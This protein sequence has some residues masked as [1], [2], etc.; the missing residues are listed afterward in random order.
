MPADGVYL[1]IGTATSWVVDKFTH[2]V[3]RADGA[4]ISAEDVTRSNDGYHTTGMV[5]AVTHLHAG[6][7]VSM[8]SLQ[9]ISSFSNFSTALTGLLIQPDF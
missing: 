6:Q 8:E 7:T 4:E 9:K 1:F 5:H 2:I 3:L